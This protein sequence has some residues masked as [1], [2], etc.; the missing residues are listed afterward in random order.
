MDILSGEKQTLTRPFT[1]LS[2]PDPAHLLGMPGPVP[3]RL[4]KG[5]LGST[6]C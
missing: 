2:G 1:A 5:L 3:T 4:I 6:M